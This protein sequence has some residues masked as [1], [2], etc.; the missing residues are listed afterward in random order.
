MREAIKPKVGLQEMEQHEDAVDG[1]CPKVDGVESC[2]VIPNMVLSV[3]NQREVD[4]LVENIQPPGTPPTDL[5]W[6]REFPVVPR[7]AF[8]R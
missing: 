3:V 6:N 1:Q 8:V 4:E 7:I 2:R 5:R